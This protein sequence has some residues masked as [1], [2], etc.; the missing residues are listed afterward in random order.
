[1][2]AIDT[3]VLIEILDKKSEKGDEVLKQILQGGEEICITV[4]NMHEI[5]YGLHKYGKPVK[6][7]LLLPVLNYMKKDAALS[8]KIELEAEERGTSIRRTDAM[9]AAIAI[10]NGAALFT[11]DLKHFS[12]LKALGLKLFP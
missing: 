2:I 5:L 8:S 9:I 4:I 1:M 6:E 11:F 7:I 3:D 12:P 10:N